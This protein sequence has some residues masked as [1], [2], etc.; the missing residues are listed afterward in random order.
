M[1]IGFISMPLSGH[2]NPMTALARSVQARGHEV[3]FF[4]LPDAGRVVR[5]AG[6][7]FVTF[8]EKEY[9][10]G[11][12]PKAYSHLAR[13]T[14]EAVARYSFQ[15]MHPR[16]CKTTLD[17]LPARLETEDVDGLVIDT[18]H[19]FAELAAIRLSIPYVHIW[20]ILPI[21]TSGQ[22]PPCFFGWPYDNSAAA[23]ARNLE[24]VNKYR[25]N[26]TPVIAVAKSWAQSQGL[27][28]DWNEPDATLSKRALITQTPRE[29]DF[30]N[31]SLPDHFYYAGP[32]KEERG[33]EPIHFPWDRLTGLP[34]IYASMGTLVN[35]DEGIF[36]SIIEAVAGIKGVQLVLSTGNNIDINAL[37]SLPSNT[38]VAPSLPQ[39]ALL[40]RA[41]MC[42][43]HAG[44]NTVLEA[45]SAGV[46]LVAIPVGFDQPG[47]AAR[48]T[49][50]QV[51]QSLPA[52]TLTPEAL[53][54][55]IRNV[56]NNPIFRCN[57]Q[58]LQKVIAK[59]NGLKL[60]A[61][62]IETALANANLVPADPN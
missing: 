18:V 25:A 6:L 35:G 50:H 13:L 29:F 39:V 61:G 4:G 38:I 40:A 55:A 23:I 26:L 41:H 10:V 16:R 34:V 2:L 52:A 5:F 7:R 8:G 54:A 30:P 44:I 36:N 32:F 48:I 45:L 1:K 20:N 12:T 22:T 47:I 49:Y 60:A 42:I 56:L 31:P 28:I 57:A 59:T 53:S 15:E 3:V 37:R 27:Q 33:R 17:Q 19:Y 62:L 58:R 43:T 14:G 51:G 24:A 9:P 21:D 46:P 11:A